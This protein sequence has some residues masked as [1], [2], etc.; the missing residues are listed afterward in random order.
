M[1]IANSESDVTCDTWLCVLQAAR[2]FEPAAHNFLLSSLELARQLRPNGLWGY[3]M[4]PYCYNF[5]PNNMR[6]SCP[7]EVKKENDE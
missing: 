2:Q 5:A 6:P 7:A 4:F 1:C 3:Y